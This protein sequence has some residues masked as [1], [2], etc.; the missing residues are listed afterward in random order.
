VRAHSGAVGRGA[1]L[2]TGERLAFCLR[3]ELQCCCRSGQ[4]LAPFYLS[5]KLLLKVFVGL[6]YV[7]DS[8]K[9]EFQRIGE[10]D[11]DT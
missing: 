3:L 4:P 11:D 7:F 5:K 2:T 8:E 9:P 6:I 1:G 10:A